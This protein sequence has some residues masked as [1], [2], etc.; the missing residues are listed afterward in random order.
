MPSN[1]VWQGRIAEGLDPRAKALNDSLR[2][3]GRLWPEEI[4]LSRAYAQSLSECG[5]LDADSL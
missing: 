2:F 5:V 4:A 1:P 3:D